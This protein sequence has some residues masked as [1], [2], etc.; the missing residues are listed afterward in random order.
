M[1]E[2][3]AA[4]EEDGNLVDVEVMYDYKRMTTLFM[5][6]SSK[7]TVIASYQKYRPDSI[8]VVVFRHTDEIF[9]KTNNKSTIP[10]NFMLLR[11]SQYLIQ[12]L[13][14]QM[15]LDRGYISKDCQGDSP[16]ADDA[17][18]AQNCMPRFHL[19]DR[20]VLVQRQDPNLFDIETELHFLKTDSS[21][22]ANGFGP[23]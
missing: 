12:G 8:S 14:R 7:Y 2:Q 17:R 11:K 13:N 21:V 19:T 1:L 22:E 10:A 3:N 23:I 4:K 9:F 20:Y 5:Q 18:A 6:T 16:F 15:L